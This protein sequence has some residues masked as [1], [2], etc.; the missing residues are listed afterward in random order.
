MKRIALNQPG[1]DCIYDVCKDPRPCQTKPPM[2]PRRLPPGSHGIGGEQW[3]YTVLH[4]ERGIAV[5]LLVLTDILPPTV[6]A[7]HSAR[8]GIDP[9]W[10]DRPI[11]RRRTGGWLKVHVRREVGAE[12]C[13]IFAGSPCECEDLGALFADAFFREH[14]D[15]HQFEQ[16]ESLWAALETILAEHLEL[17]TQ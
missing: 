14:G 4:E 15:P 1:H 10:D 11:E 9:A 2:D 7:D 3:W 6:P 13:D 8:C 16:P 12:P 5:R 17:R